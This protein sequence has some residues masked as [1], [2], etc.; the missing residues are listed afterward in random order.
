MGYQVW[1]II[2]DRDV[3][4]RGDIADLWIQCDDN[5]SLLCVQHDHLPR[6]SQEFLGELQSAHPKKN[7]S[8]L[9]LLNCRR[10][11]SLTPD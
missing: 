6:E 8:S 4:C 10:C 7:C 9:M 2:M 1:N 5:F 11:T 3:L